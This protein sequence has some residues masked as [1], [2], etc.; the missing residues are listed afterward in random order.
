MSKHGVGGWVGNHFSGLNS[1]DVN[2]SIVG[3]PKQVG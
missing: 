1:L 3:Q 2:T